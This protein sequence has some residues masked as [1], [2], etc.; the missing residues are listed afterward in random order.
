MIIDV[1]EYPKDHLFTEV[2]AKEFGIY[3][4]VAQFNEHHDIRMFRMIVDSDLS[5]ADLKKIMSARICDK[6]GGYVFDRI[7][8]IS[9]P[10][11]DD[12]PRM[13]MTT[14]YLRI[15]FM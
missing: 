7:E 13:A 3:V 9:G 5:V 1:R 4:H 6:A 15:T 8:S 14:N 11:V 10:I 2:V 12:G